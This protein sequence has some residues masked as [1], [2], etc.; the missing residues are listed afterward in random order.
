[1]AGVSKVISASVL[2][3]LQL[4]HP[5]HGCTRGSLGQS[6]PF[7]SKVQVTSAPKAT[8]VPHTDR[9]RSYSS[10]ITKLTRG[11]AGYEQTYRK[12]K[13]PETHT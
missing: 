13:L 5:E 11:P 1:M 10:L 6:L 7:P 4:P 8:M 2:L 3:A 9:A 12:N